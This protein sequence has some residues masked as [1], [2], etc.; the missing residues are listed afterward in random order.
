MVDEAR[1]GPIQ[2]TLART[3]IGPDLIEEMDKRRAGKSPASPR[4]SSARRAFAGRP[5]TPAPGEAATRSGPKR[6]GCGRGRRAAA[7][8]NFPRRDR[9]EHRL[10]RRR[11]ARARHDPRNSSSRNAPK[12]SGRWAG[13]ARGGATAVRQHCPRPRRRCSRPRTRSPSPIRSSPTTISSP[14]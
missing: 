5:P 2:K 7:G 10:S 9:A 6:G 4:S 13:A 12:A 3:G 1:S 14:S 11:G 8:R